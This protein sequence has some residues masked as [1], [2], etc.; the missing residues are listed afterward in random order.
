MMP[1][2]DGE[3]TVRTVLNWPDT[4]NRSW[5][6]GDDHSV[7]A[8]SAL[9]LAYLDTGVGQHHAL[10]DAL[11]DGAGDPLTVRA[12][13]H[14]FGLAERDR[15]AVVALR[16]M[17]RAAP[18]DVEGLSEHVAGLRIIWRQRAHGIVGVVVLGA[19]NVVDLRAALPVIPGWCVGISSVIDRLAELSVAKEQAELS[20]AT[21]SHSGVAVLDEHLPAALLAARPDLAQRLAECTLGAILKLS[22]GTRETMLETLATWMR[23][24]GSSTATA[25][26]LGCHRNTV[27]NRLRRFEACSR[28]SLTSPADLAAI[29][30]ALD[31]VRLQ[32]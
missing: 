13:V 28:L 4:A 19:H 30:L 23:C 5:P 8:L 12:T 26:S 15:Y 11:F 29:S 25:A 27:L 16:P 2:S 9:R 21:L 17:G 24:N 32:P 14:A 6:L 3:E 22:R 18:L 31:A 7:R 1:I 10:L 20:C